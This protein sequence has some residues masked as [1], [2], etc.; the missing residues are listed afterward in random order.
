MYTEG[1][2]YRILNSISDNP[3][4]DAG[5]FRDLSTF[6]SGKVK[7]IEVRDPVNPISYPITILTGEFINPRTCKTILY[8][9]DPEGDL[10]LSVHNTAHV[11][12]KY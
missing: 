4:S 8:W 5:Y 11:Y 10:H 2:A 12:I 7:A 1:E 9:S 3:G 6:R